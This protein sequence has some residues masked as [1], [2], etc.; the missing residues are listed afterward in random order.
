M[1]KKLF[2]ISYLCEFYI[3]IC[4]KKTKFTNINLHPVF[5]YEI[6][7]FRYQGI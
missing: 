5:E 7:S 1:L 4:Q 3:Q 2:L 6:V